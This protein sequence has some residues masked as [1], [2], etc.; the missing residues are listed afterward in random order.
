M[1]G[2]NKSRFVT[3]AKLPFIHNYTKKHT[4][5]TRS[6]DSSHVIHNY[7]QDYNNKIHM[8][9]M[10]NLSATGDDDGDVNVENYGACAQ[11]FHALQHATAAS[12]TTT[13][14]P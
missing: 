4:N 5:K 10:I 13:P 9:D 2:R 6:E 3:D 14:W 1:N 8:N 12:P 7:K 11:S